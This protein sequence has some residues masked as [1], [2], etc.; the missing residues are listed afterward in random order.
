MPQYVAYVGLTATP[1]ANLLQDTSSRLYPK[2]FVLTLR[3][4]GDRDSSLTYLEPEFDRRH[5]GGYTFYEAME[6]HQ[7]TNFLVRSDMSDQEFQGMEGP[8]QALEEALIAYF[9]AGAIRLELHPGSSLNDPRRLAPPHTM[10]AHTESRVE[11]HW[12]LCERVVGLTRHK[13]GRSREVRENLR[14]ISPSARL[15][16]EHLATW[17]RNE[18]ERW[19]RWYES[20]RASREKLLLVAPDRTVA[21]LPT[22]EETLRHLSSV[23]RGV[24]LRVVNSDDTSSDTPLQFQPSFSAGGVK[25]P[26]DVYSIIIGGNRLSR[27]LTIEGLCVSYYTRSSTQFLEDTTIQRERW[28]GY[29]GSHLE[30]CRL[31][32]HRSMAVRFQSFHQHDEDLRRQ[33]AW[34]VQNGRKPVDATFRFLTMRDSLP[35]AKLGRGK[36]P[37]EIDVAGSKPFVDRV[38]MGETDEEKAVAR[39]NQSHASEHA[40]RIVERGERLLSERNELLGYVLRGV[41]V[42]EVA[43]I[44]E[45]F[46]YTFHNPEATRGVGWNLREYYRPPADRIPVTPAR[47]PPRSDPLLIAAYLKYWA[48][49]FEQC[50]QDPSKNVS[51]GQTESL[52]GGHARHRSSMSPC[53]VDHSSHRPRAPSRSNCSTGRST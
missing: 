48:A 37:D 41:S 20:F 9:V 3:T 50:R 19:H 26:T 10:M 45:G 53:A 16:P 21:R 28:F 43:A 25:A 22:W 5:T 24:K 4:P 15:D 27:G 6:A 23:F 13:A 39:A 29:R 32:T 36:G 49:G 51:V 30:F 34:N 42:G 11:S 8:D 12:A 44:L 33:L 7:R 1:A 46:T 17:L 14:R 47:L 38:Q 18:S 52:H 40:T 31:F 2:A 35:T